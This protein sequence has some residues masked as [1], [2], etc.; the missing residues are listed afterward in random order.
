M[1]LARPLTVISPTVDADVLAALASADSAFTGRQLHRVIQRHSQSGVNRVLNRLVQEGIVARTT[2]GAAKSYS[3]NRDHLQANAIVELVRVR[4]RLIEQLEAAFDEWARGPYFAAMYGSAA[5]GEHDS[6]SDIDLIVVRP[7]DIADDDLEWTD[8]LVELRTAV[9][10]WTGNR[11]D[12][13][14]YSRAEIEEAFDGG[15]PFITG[16]GRRMVVLAGERSYLH[17][18]APRQRRTTRG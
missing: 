5:G 16:M 8:D 1:D 11:C 15:D 10:R 9:T 7:D 12:V 18:A 2:V 6:E 14:E 3:L 13:V 17:R 4:S